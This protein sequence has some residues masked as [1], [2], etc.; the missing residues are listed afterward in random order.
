MGA[1]SLSDLPTWRDPQGIARLAWLVVANRGVAPNHDLQ[2]IRQTLGT[3]VVE[4]V[5]VATM[6]GV[7][8]SA[9]DIRRRVA[10]GK[11][12]RYM[13]PRGVECYIAEHR[14]YAN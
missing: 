8:F 1:D 11:S 7:D 14:L 10:E 6:P 3:A 4:R 5:L 9:H 2:T 13:T 12:I